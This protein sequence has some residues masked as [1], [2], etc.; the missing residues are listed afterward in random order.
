MKCR[1][2]VLSV[3]KSQTAAVRSEV[4]PFLIAEISKLKNQTN[5][6]LW[7]YDNMCFSEDYFWGIFA[8]QRDR[9]Y[10]AA[11]EPDAGGLKCKRN[12]LLSPLQP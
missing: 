12:A 3:D 9:K 11:L 2:T 1:H 7:I 6:V 10:V 5:K 8:A 4:S